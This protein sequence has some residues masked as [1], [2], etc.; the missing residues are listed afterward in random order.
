MTEDV[1]SQFV[2]EDLDNAAAM[3]TRKEKEL[4]LAHKKE[5]NFLISTWSSLSFFGR[6]RRLFP[7]SMTL[8]LF[9]FREGQIDISLGLD[10]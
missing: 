9:R 1:A 10:L 3:G 7:F 4:A 6:A 2:W 5:I 8:C